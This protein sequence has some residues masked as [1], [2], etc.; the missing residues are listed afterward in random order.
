MEENAELGSPNNSANPIAPYMHALDNM[1]ERPD[2]C[3]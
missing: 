1:L 3:N 2:P